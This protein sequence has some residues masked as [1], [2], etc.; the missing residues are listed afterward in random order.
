[1]CT[2]WQ[3]CFNTYTAII[4]KIDLAVNCVL[5]HNVPMPLIYAKQ[6]EGS[7]TYICDE[8]TIYVQKCM[9]IT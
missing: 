6:N 8:V 5:A 1:M 2:I 4:C 3:A 7:M 9:P